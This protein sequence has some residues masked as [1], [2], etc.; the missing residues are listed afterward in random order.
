MA[1]VFM[2]ERNLDTS[3][4]DKQN[5]N[6]GPGEY[7]PQSSFKKFNAN[8]QPFLTG[9]PRS[10]FDVKDTPGPGAYY[11]DETH[12][13]YLKNL[14]NEKISMQNDKINLL[15]KGE[16]ENLTKLCLLMNSEKKGFNIKSK[17]FRIV[18]TTTNQ[19]GPGQYFQNNKLEKFEKKK[20]K[21]LKENEAFIGKKLSLIKTSEFQKIPT[22]PSKEK[23]FGFDILKNGTLIQKQN[24][25]M[26][27][28]F[29]GEKGDTVGP[30]SYEI[31]KP[32][33]WHKTGTSWS[34]FRVVRDCNKNLNKND[35]SSSMTTTNYSDAKKNNNNLLSGVLGSTSTD[36]TDRTNNNK[37]SKSN[38]N[39]S[40]EKSSNNIKT[41]KKNVFNLV[42]E[43]CK[44]NNKKKSQ[45]PITFDNIIKKV[46]PG[47]GYYYD[48][49]SFTSFNVKYVP[50]YK[51]YFGSRLAR[52]INNR[53]N[54][55]NSLGPGD[56]FKEEKNNMSNNNNSKKVAPFSSSKER[57][58]Y[59]EDKLDI[60]GPGE[61][62]NS[63][64]ENKNKM[65]PG[66]DNKFGSSEIR[67]NN[68]YNL[69]WKSGVPGPG[70][71]SP[72]NH[73]KRLNKTSKNF[74]KRGQFFS[75]TKNDL[76]KYNYNK[77]NN[78]S[79]E[80]KDSVPPIGLYNPDIV[81]S[82]DYKVKKNVYET[83]NQKVA[84][85]SSF[86]KRKKKKNNIVINCENSNLGPGY[87]YHERKKIDNKL[88]PPF[89]LPEFKRNIKSNVNIFV[90]P[91][92]YELDSYNTWNK[93][94]FNINFV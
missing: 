6:L 7:L 12:N 84:F 74:N 42:I 64:Q 33:N 9:S 5:C 35:F 18:N 29:T 41:N 21:K 75:T 57:F 17:R 16:R 72:D 70:F 37:N 25:D 40:N 82:I 50:E 92:K 67:F 43:T 68:M 62:D 93:K 59:A 22:I 87:Y 19:P 48:Q 86:N 56:Y 63:N 1:M 2:S 11:H 78:S 27:R 23:Q 53:S 10:K 71:Y 46:T 80:L 61:Y 15:T 30:G 91:G 51:Q 89:H 65:P 52:F 47:P 49:K 60:P 13:N 85:S 20:I 55:T 28:T 26:Y 94:S 8:K 77:I 83:K 73:S 58:P 34:K 66:P 24:P 36:L 79:D 90:G 69:N 32:N 4:I 88:S 44:I 39:I 3:Q 81:S 54:V 14:Y 38:I 45:Q 76:E 31:E